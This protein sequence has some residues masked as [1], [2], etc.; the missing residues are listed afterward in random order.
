L[1]L[2]YLIQAVRQSGDRNKI[3]IMEKNKYLLTMMVAKRAKAITCWGKAP[4]KNQI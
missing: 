1:I 2:F 4:D 3:G